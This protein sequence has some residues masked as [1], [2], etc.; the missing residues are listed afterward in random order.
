MDLGKTNG[1]IVFKRMA[2]MFQLPTQRVVV[3][4]LETEQVSFEKIILDIL[5]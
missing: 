5:F 4:V 3:Y 1:I 2:S